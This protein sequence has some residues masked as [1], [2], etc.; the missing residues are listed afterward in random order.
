MRANPSQKAIAV[1]AD[2]RD[3]NRKVTAELKKV[4]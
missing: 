4:G 3:F 1:H 2:L